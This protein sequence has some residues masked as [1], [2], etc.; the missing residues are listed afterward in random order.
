MKK[1]ALIFAALS[2]GFATHSQIAKGTNFIG[3]NVHFLG[4]SNSVTGFAEDKSSSFALDVNPNFGHFVKDNLALGVNLNFGMLNSTSTSRIPFPSE[5]ELKNESEL[6]IYGGGVFL[7]KYK[8]ITDNF[9]FFVNVGA[10]YNYLTTEN[11]TI[12]PPNIDPLP[13]SMGNTGTA[14][15]VGAA[16]SPGIVYFATP[17]LGIELSYGSLH[18]S[19]SSGETR[20]NGGSKENDK[21]H[22][23]GINLGTSSLAIGLNYYF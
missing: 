12:Y 15:R 20:Y 18:Y 4:A 22:N 1:T 17:K 2:L 19:H 8:N 9:L 23:Y 11:R 6:L 3:G 14:H 5:F 13:Q 10:G 16:I 7:R 21:T